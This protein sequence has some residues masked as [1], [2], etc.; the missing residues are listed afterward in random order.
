MLT[1]LAALTATMAVVPAATYVS[2]VIKRR[3]VRSCRMSHPEQCK[4]SGEGITTDPKFQPALIAFLKSVPKGKYGY[5]GESAW[6]PFLRSMSEG[7]WVPNW[8]GNGLYLFDGCILHACPVRQS[9]VVIVRGR[10]VAAAMAGFL[11][12]RCD[13]GLVIFVKKNDPLARGAVSALV[14]W[15]PYDDPIMEILP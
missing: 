11:C 10:I 13:D 6:E 15:G 12:R 2:D 1:I 7:P 8:S 14:R 5:K 3:P 4:G 9:A